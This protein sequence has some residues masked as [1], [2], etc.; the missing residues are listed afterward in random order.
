MKTRIRRYRVLAFFI[1]CLSMLIGLTEIH[2]ANDKLRVLT[3]NAWLLP[4]GK[5]QTS[6]QY[7]LKSIPNMI[8]KTNADI[9]ALQEV[10]PI[11]SILDSNN[12]SRSYLINSLKH[13]YK[14]SYYN[15]RLCSWK[16]W[17]WSPVTNQKKLY[18][19]RLFPPSC[20]SG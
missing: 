4:V 3:F 8:L 19:C 20:F 16:I 15:E 6:L 9:V 2:E 13:I 18:Y 7:R 5:S 12:K 17:K 11:P 10:W 14:N 1:M